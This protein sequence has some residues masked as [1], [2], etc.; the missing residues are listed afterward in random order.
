MQYSQKGVHRLGKFITPAS[1]F[2]RADRYQHRHPFQAILPT[3]VVHFK[4]DSFVRLT[5]QKK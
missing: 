1:S 4:K 5:I 3:V 2:V